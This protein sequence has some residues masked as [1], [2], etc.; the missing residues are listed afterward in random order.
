MQHHLGAGASDH[1]NF[2][3]WQ[4]KAYLV[5]NYFAQFPA[6]PVHYF[7]LLFNTAEFVGPRHVEVHTHGVIRS[8]ALRMGLSS[9]FWCCQHLSCQHL[10]SYNTVNLFYHDVESTVWRR[11]SRSTCCVS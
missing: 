2:K 9:H 3:M 11:G 1:A 7:H 5:S 8:A 4:G 10:G 6:S